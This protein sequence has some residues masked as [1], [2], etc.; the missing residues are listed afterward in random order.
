MPNP[1]SEAQNATQITSTT[2]ITT[3]AGNLLGIFV[4]SVSGSPTLAASDGATVKFATFVPAAATFYPMP[5]R[6]GTS[7]V[8]TVGATC[9]CTVCWGT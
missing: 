7:L 6:F 2:T 5:M 8:V 1:V 9:S 3:N 4:S